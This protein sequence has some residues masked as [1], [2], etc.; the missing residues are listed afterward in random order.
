[1]A[2]D[3]KM[4]PM[5]HGNKLK[6][7]DLDYDLPKDRIAQYPA[8]PR[9]QAKLIIVNRDSDSRD[10]VIFRDI[11]DYF[12]E[13]DLLVVNNTRVY[14][15]ILNAVKEDTGDEVRVF[16]LRELGNNIWD[17]SIEPINK[18]RIGNSLSLGEDLDC[19]IVDNTA[20]NER[21]IRFYE[22]RSDVQQALERT[23]QMPLPPYISRNPEPEDKEHYQTIF[24]RI[25]GAVAAPSAELHF[26]ESVLETLREQGVRI[27]ELTLHLRF[28]S[29]YP[30]G[31]S[32]LSRYQMQPEYYDISVE[33]VDAVNEAKDR[34]NRVIAGSA[35]VVRALE[36]SH[37]RTRLMKPKQHW[38]DLFIYPPHQFTIVDGLIS[39][40]HQPQS[41][42]LMLQSAF[43]G[44]SQMKTV[45]QEAL[46]RAY[47]FLGFGD[48]MFLV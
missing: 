5:L 15:A 44:T 45:Y 10:H 22:D 37:F 13:G 38:T 41:T 47:R 11:P 18:A 25:P 36:S 6:S 23:G 21:V 27:V 7:E 26:T 2:S 12:R 20:A 46:D 14:P 39:N 17:V 31:I 29:H 9:D 33:T 30:V 16:L 48:A 42:T 34:G 8:E 35:S 28:D 4:D 40:F 1:M 3:Q 24:A 19:E 43:Y 32:D